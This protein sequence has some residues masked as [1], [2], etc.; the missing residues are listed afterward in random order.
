[1]SQS[2]SGNFTQHALLVAWGQFA[3]CLGLIRQVMALNLHQKKVKHL[4]QTKIL[5]FFLAILAGL[6]YLK[7][8]SQAAHPIA[9]DQA[10]AK[11]WD[12]PA[13]SDYS[14]VSRCLSELSQAEAEQV[15]GVLA[16]I[17]QPLIDREVMLALSQQ[18]VL[19]YDGDLTHRPVSNTSTSYPNAAYGHMGAGV[20]FGYQAAL[21]SF[22]SPTYGRLWLS[23]VPHPGD[24]ISCTQGEALV[25]AAEAKTGMRPR[26]RVELLAERLKTMKRHRLMLQQRLLES[27]RALQK[28]QTQLPLTV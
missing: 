21:V 19:V 2:E 20:G 26:R 22:H 15:A 16:A 1:M 28:A 24:V 7:D 23:A 6:E 11:A 14:G 10:V 3:Q 4:P 27:Q 17:S 13:W 8:L 25:L 5:E 12:Q 18:G 9:Q